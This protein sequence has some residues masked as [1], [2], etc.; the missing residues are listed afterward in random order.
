MNRELSLHKVQRALGRYG[1][2]GW[3][4]TSAP[5]YLI[6]ILPP[7]EF[8]DEYGL[9]EKAGWEV[10]SFESALAFING[11]YAA[12]YLERHKPHRPD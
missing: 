10:A 6:K 7:P 9:N 12:R 3:R 4:F 11:F 1:E 8:R 2:D 5:G